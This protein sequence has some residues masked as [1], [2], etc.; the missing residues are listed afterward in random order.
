MDVDQ[1]LQKFH[2]QP[3][4]KSGPQWNIKP[5]SRI[6]ELHWRLHLIGWPYMYSSQGIASSLQNSRIEV[7]L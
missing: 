5:Y 3:N 4:L 1:Y 6:Y 7:P 2:K